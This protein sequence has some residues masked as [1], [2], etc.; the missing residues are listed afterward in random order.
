[1][2]TELVGAMERSTWAVIMAGGKGT[3]LR[4]ITEN[5]PK[6]MLRVAGRPILERIVLHLVSYGIR[7]VYLAINYMGHVIEDH[8]GHGERFG[9]R[10][11]YLRET[12]PLGTGGPLSLL[13]GP[14][15]E[16]LLVLNGDLVMQV[17]VDAMLSFHTTGQYQAT[18]G[19]HQYYHEVP[20][21]CLELDGAR[22][23][24]M[25]EKPVLDKIINA[26]IYVLEPTL[27]KYVP[28][29]FFPITTLLEESLARGERQGA[30]MIEDEW[31]DVGHRDELRRAQKGS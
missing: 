5:L 11:D 28:Q 30:F 6:P 7:Q 9:C 4:P 18:V 17:D 21:G 16:P 19:V 25:E 2:L 14:P 31:I 23:L 22:I 29:R 13:P 12:E 3:R 15:A 27:L 20:F 8:F 10:I 26:G 1:L 24:R